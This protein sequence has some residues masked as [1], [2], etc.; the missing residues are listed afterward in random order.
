VVGPSEFL[1]IKK[2]GNEGKGK[3][4]FNLVKQAGIRGLYSGIVPTMWRDV[5]TFGAYFSAYEFFKNK[6][7][8]S[9]QVSD[10]TEKDCKVIRQT[11]Y[12][13]E[14]FGKMVAGGLAGQVCWSLS[15]PFDVIK[16]YMQYHPEQKGTIQTAKY[17]YH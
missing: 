14:F 8:P 15:Y 13:R 4:Y 5:P 2:Q 12:K 9:P 7:I 10:S 1:K 16:S 11:S 17:I 3:S 6:L